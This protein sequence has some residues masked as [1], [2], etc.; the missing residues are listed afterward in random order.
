M[1]NNSELY[2]EIARAIYKEIVSQNRKITGFLNSANINISSFYAWMGANGLHKKLV[3][4]FH[5]RFKLL[6]LLAKI[7]NEPISYEVMSAL[8]YDNE[9]NSEVVSNYIKRLL[10]NEKQ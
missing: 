1:S 9:N 8:A 7:R 6:D 5:S 4:G 10:K 3:P 2:Y